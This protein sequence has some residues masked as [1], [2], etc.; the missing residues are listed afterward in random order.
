MKIKD[1]PLY[2]PF[3]RMK[4]LVSVCLYQLTHFNVWACTGSESL[5]ISNG[6][7]EK[8]AQSRSFRVSQIAIFVAQLLVLSQR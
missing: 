5:A 3:F 6:N 2:K 8:G 4:R 7:E 1:D